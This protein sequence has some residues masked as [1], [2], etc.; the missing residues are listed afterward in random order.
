MQLQKHLL[1][2]GDTPPTDRLLPVR[3][4]Q[5]WEGC[6]LAVPRCLHAL[7]RSAAAQHSHAGRWLQLQA[8]VPHALA[9]DTWLESAVGQLRNSQSAAIPSAA[10][11][12]VAASLQA[13][14]DF[15]PI[16]PVAV[17]QLQVALGAA[18]DTCWAGRQGRP[19]AAAQTGLLLP[20]ACWPAGVPALLHAAHVLPPKAAPAQQLRPRL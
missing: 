13:P 8:G 10:A 17:Q 6:Q 3:S 19:A 16:G 9:A 12:A 20:A 2:W 11:A 15:G 5:S 7:A 4:L 1:Q 14:A 18:L